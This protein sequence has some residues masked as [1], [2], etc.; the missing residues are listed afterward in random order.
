M[1]PVEKTHQ[2]EGKCY[3]KIPYKKRIIAAICLGQ[4]TFCRE[5]AW[6]SANIRVRIATGATSCQDYIK[7][8]VTEV[9]KR[10]WLQMY[11]LCATNF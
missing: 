10:V 4:K 3:R 7:R 8:I 6:M 1:I 9:K 2:Y 11:K 5:N